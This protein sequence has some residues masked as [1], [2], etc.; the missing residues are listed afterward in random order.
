M[1]KAVE[2]VVAQV[3]SDEAERGALLSDGLFGRR[4]TRSA[5]DAAAIMVDRAHSAWKEDN[6]AGVILMDI[7][8]AFLTIA[9]GRLIHAMKAK[10]INGDLIQWTESFITDR[11]VEMVIEGNVLQIHPV[12]A[13][14]PQG[15]PVSP[16]LIAIHTAG[17]IKGVEERVQC[18]ECLSFVDDLGWVATG[19]DLNQKVRKL[20]ACATES[21]EWASRRDLQFNTAK[22][23]PALFTR[24]RGHKKHLRP[25]LTAEIKV[26][27]G[28]VRFKKETTRR[29]GVWTDD[30]RTFKEHYN[31]CMKKDRAAEARL[32]ILTRMVGILP[33]RVRAV[34][35][36]FVQAV[37]LYG[38][39][40]WWD[41]KEIGRREDRQLLLN[42][43]ARSTLGA[44]PTTPLG[45]LMRD[46]GLTPAAVVLD[47]RQQ[48]FAARLATACK[49]SKQK[50]TFKHP[51]SG[52]RICRVIKEEHERG[53]EAET[54]CLPRPDEELAVKTVI[55]RDDGAAKGQA[56]CW[57]SEREA[58]VGP[59]VG[60]RWTDGSQS[61]DGRVGAA[62]VCKHRDGWK[63]FC[64]HLGTG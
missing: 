2:K 15:S 20:E 1:G 4:K 21:I 30:H 19:K 37:A 56:K 60:M 38:S 14:V 61:D 22:T 12:E 13:G 49:G 57:G 25:K 5:I 28:F 7:K 32:R 44:L 8:A 10:Q 3:L 63:Q 35:V 54:M 59:G 36:A 43:P 53:R 17:L 18:I 46:S 26:R 24:R 55:L 41:T 6:I 16:I 48:R 31:R 58:N 40:L 51:T 11:T 64:S 29:L 9:R 45:P 39:E 23:E 50:E 62:V 33:E 52:A 47:S 34:H 27:D 42:R